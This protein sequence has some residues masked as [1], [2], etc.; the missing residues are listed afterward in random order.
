MFKLT[1][2]AVAL[3]PVLAAVVVTAVALS[4]TASG[5]AALRFA[6]GRLGVTAYA[7]G[8]GGSGGGIDHLTISRAELTAKLAVTLTVTYMC[9]PVFDPNTGQLDVFFSS[10]QN[11]FLQERTGKTVANGSGFG[12]GT[13]ICDEGLTSTPTVNQATILV[14]PDVFP[15][16]GPFKNGAALATV[17][18][19]ACPNVFVASGVPPPCEFG[20]LNNAIISI[21]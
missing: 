13:A 17:Q 8:G 1:R 18:V 2:S 21:K 12:N 5:S 7:A 9:Q 15:A 14:T 6:A 3:I 19:F 20:S 4:S 11:A 10:F 16:S